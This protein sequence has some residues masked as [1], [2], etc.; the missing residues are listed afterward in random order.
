MLSLSRPV[1]EVS[2]GAAV[3]LTGR[4]ERVDDASLEQREPGCDWQ[5][6][7]ALGRQSDGSFSVAVAPT[8]TTQF[9]LAAGTIRSAVLSVVVAPP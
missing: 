2:P 8:A 5:P 6:G 7:P 3:T 9:R 4:V 1:G